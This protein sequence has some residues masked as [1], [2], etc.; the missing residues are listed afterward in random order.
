[1]ARRYF[2]SYGL[3]SGKIG[4]RQNA[5]FLDVSCGCSSAGGDRPDFFLRRVD[6]KWT[7]HGANNQQNPSS[8][9]G[10]MASDVLVP[11]AQKLKFS[12][13]SIFGP[14]SMSVSPKV[15]KFWIW[16]KGWYLFRIG[17]PKGG[18]KI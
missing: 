17:K 3:L 11:Q 5:G 2:L 8:R 18:V 4:N 15:I 12:K 14:S 6:K 9:Y 10:A 1:M 16:N 13:K 7:Y